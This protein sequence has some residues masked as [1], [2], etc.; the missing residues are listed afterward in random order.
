VVERSS[1][2]ERTLIAPVMSCISMVLVAGM[3]SG[4][5]SLTIFPDYAL[6]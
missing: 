4:M 2:G 3:Y 5:R 6:V 1:G